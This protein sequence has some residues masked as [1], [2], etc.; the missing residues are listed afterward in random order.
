VSVSELNPA[1]MVMV[2]GEYWNALATARISPSEPVRITAI[3]GLMLRVE[4][5]RELERK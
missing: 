2:R 5:A 3:D 1:G 4:A